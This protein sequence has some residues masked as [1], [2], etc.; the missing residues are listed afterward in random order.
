MF[1]GMDPSQFDP[2]KMDPKLLMELSQLIQTLPPSTL[3]Q[4]QGLM[5]NAMAGLD[6]RKEVEEFEKTLPQDFREKMLSL[7]SRQMAAS[8]NKAPSASPVHSLSSVTAAEMDMKQARLTVLQAV[9][10]G[11]VSAEEALQALFPSG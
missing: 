7:M 11:S 4:M 1:P 10:N 3:N 5:H 2:S 6:V 9:A 8:P